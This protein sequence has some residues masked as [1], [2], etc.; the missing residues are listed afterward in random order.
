MRTILS[1]ALLLAL[2]AAPSLAQTPEVGWRN[3]GATW[4]ESFVQGVVGSPQCPGIAD[5]EAAWAWWAETQPD[6]LLG[7]AMAA[8]DLRTREQGGLCELAIRFTP[9]AE[10][11]VYIDAWAERCGWT[12]DSEQTPAQHV[13]E[14]L[15]DRWRVLI[16]GYRRAGAPDVDPGP[17]RPARPAG[18]EG[19]PR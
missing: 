11:Q 17:I 12:E 2:L 4:A 3:S 15:P 1:I 19:G 18:P 5:A 8:L 6:P 10:A 16:K 13:A 9:A 7:A 14:C